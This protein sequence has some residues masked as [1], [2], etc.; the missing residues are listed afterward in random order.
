MQNIDFQRLNEATNSA[1]TLINLLPSFD[2]KKSHNG[3]RAKQHGGHSIYCK[4]SQW[5]F[6]A[7]NGDYKG[8]TPLAVA[9]EINGLDL[10]TKDGLFE[11][12]KFV[13]QAANLR[14]SD[15][16][17]D[18][19][20]EAYTH[21]VSRPI[22]T[23]AFLP[24]A[25]Q[26]LS[27]KFTFEI[28][29][30][31][32]DT[33]KAAAK[34]YERKTGVKQA[35]NVVFLQTMTHIETGKKTVFNHKKLGISYLSN[36]YAANIKV[37]V[38]DT[39]KGKKKMFAIQNSS[40]Y[41]FGLD[42][43]PTEN[44]K[45]FTLLL[46][47]GEDD[48]T[49]I[50]AN[51]QPFGYCAITFGSESA[52]I[53]T[54]YLN[55]LKSQF[56]NVVCLFDADATGV[57]M[58][59]RNETQ[60]GLP[61]IS[62]G[63]TVTD[64]KD[65]CDIY[66]QYGTNKLLSVV[67]T[68]RKQPQPQ[69]QE[70]KVSNLELLI[71]DRK[72]ALERLRADKSRKIVVCESSFIDTA[73]SE[74]RG[75]NVVFCNYKDISRL[76]L[77]VLDGS[78][79]CVFGASNLPRKHYV[80]TANEIEKLS[81]TNHVT[82][83]SDTPTFLNIAY[84]VTAID[85]YTNTS[86][87]IVSD[88]PQ[89]TFVEM[90]KKHGENEVQYLETSESINRQLQ[91]FEVVK[92]AELYASDHKKPLYVLYDSNIQLLPEAF[93]QF[94]NVVYVASSEKKE[95][96]SMSTFCN[97]M[98]KAADDALQF[99]DN[100]VFRA[101]IEKVLFETV[102]DKT[103]PIR[104][105]NN[106]KKWERCPNLATMLETEHE[107][108]VLYS[109]ATELQKRIE[110]TN[111]STIENSVISEDTA[112]ISEDIKQAKKDLATEKKDEYEEFLQE[113]EDL[114]INGK[115]ELTDFVSDKD[116]MTRGGKIAYNRLKTLLKVNDDFSMCFDAVR[117]SY[118]GWTQTKGRFY[119]AKVVKTSTKIGKSLQLFRDT[120]NGTQY[121]KTDLIDIARATLNMVNGNDA[122]V[123]RQLKRICFLSDKRV[124]VE[125]KQSR[126]YEAIFLE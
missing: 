41:I 27:K 110:K 21:S 81:K 68:E 37:K 32:S 114:N 85:E 92:R 97:S 107:I 106:V 38:I 63:D 124:R 77:D 49:C 88:N 13:C 95:C 113:V 112:L 66:K 98:D 46:C 78:N 52:T 16:C 90:I 102:K 89:A 35:Q 79:I 15:Y 57:K 34:Y 80:N 43:L 104:Y 108:K 6:T 8:G 103:L 54:D 2:W 20:S 36:G 86:K 31:D 83:F 48:T 96:V 40:S 30:P 61:Y 33:H 65:V 91:G 18:A 1:Q 109:D 75:G 45:D 9:A 58:S 121:T 23:K 28:A 56:K 59:I 12:A 70:R 117:D 123:W 111:I 26:P 87:V 25:G 64:C 125:G 14:F 51:L 10:K 47:A 5:L 44:R 94:E 100:E 119:A 11:A 17:T 118:T 120:T 126:T 7:H 29:T 22:E 50:N 3:H 42:N 84:Q 76:T 69:P 116:E 105:D 62:I 4:S 115:S 39:E 72:N 19:P 122:E 71:I 101:K 24:N 99:V 73:E 67:K 60:N 82:L 53:P 93:A 74:L 55:Y